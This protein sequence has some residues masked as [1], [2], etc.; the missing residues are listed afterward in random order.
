MYELVVAAFFLGVAI[1]VG[2]WLALGY[3]TPHQRALRRVLQLDPWVSKAREAGFAL[4]DAINGSGDVEAAARDAAR[5]AIGLCQEVASTQPTGL[6]PLRG[7]LEAAASAA[8]SAAE[9]ATELARTIRG[10]HS[11]ILQVA[12]SAPQGRRAL[13]EAG[14][15][16]MEYLDYAEETASSLDELAGGARRAAAA[17]RA[18][19]AHR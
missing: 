4:T 12:E 15:E 18:G 14:G 16:A 19:D 5:A 7:R 3:E 9:R 8:E 11:E 10:L 6:E 13:G 17:A 2:R 1:M